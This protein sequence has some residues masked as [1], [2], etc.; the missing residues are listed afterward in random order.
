MSFP[1]IVMFLLVTPPAADVKFTHIQILS[2]EAVVVNEE[3]K[4]QYVVFM[5][6]CVPSVIPAKVFAAHTSIA[7]AP[8]GSVSFKAMLI[9]KSK[10]PVLSIVKHG[11][12]SSCAVPPTTVQFAYFV[13]PP[14]VDVKFRKF[15]HVPPADETQP[16][17][18][19][20]KIVNSTFSGTVK[21]A[22]VVTISV[23]AN[24]IPSTK[25]TVTRMATC[26]IVSLIDPPPFYSTIN[27]GHL[28]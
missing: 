1:R 23:D 21:Y 28:F 13:F 12:E 16:T 14:D 6:T 5:S 20:K 11:V 25:K 15:V 10:F 27:R 18:P 22:I 26:L 8:P 4:I 9:F 19:G 7:D 3:L 17:G 2:F 24:A